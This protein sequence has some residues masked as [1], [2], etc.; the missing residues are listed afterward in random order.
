MCHRLFER[1]PAERTNEPEFLELPLGHLLVAA[2]FSDSMGWRKDQGKPERHRCEN[3][4]HKAAFSDGAL[5]PTSAAEVAFENPLGERHHEA[6]GR[7]NHL[8]EMICTAPNDTLNALRDA[9]AT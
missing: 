8:I 9:L 1:L 6:L 4:T 7:K 5:K 2:R 3:R